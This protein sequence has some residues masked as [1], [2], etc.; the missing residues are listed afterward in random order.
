M[1]L[2]PHAAFIWASYGVFFLVLSALVLSLLWKGARLKNKLSELEAQGVT[3]RTK[4][5]AT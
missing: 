4:K 2:G 1:D 3:R 5:T